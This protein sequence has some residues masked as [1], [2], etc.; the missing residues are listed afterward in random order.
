[1]HNLH[2]TAAWWEWYWTMPALI[3]VVL[4]LW[5]LD[6]VA[7]DMRYWHRTEKRFRDR[8]VEPEVR[9]STYQFWH[10]LIITAALIVMAL[11]GAV[12]LFSPPAVQPPPPP[13]R[14]TY[15][16][17][18]MFI[19]IPMLFAVDAIYALVSRFR[20]KIADDARTYKQRRRAT[21]VKEQL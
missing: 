4:R 11:T 1:M 15:A 12:A 17:T 20:T 9:Q 16:V 7:R 18:F 2:Q 19:S 21:D 13:N 3:A 5:L 10:K 8:D 14:V 6:L